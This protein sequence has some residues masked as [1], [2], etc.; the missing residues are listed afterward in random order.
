[1]TLPAP[2]LDDRRFQDLVDE[3]KRHVQQRCPEW[4]D[5]N[6]SDPGVTLIEAF[7]SM[8]DQI[9]YRL[10]RV[11][12]RHYVK[13]LDLLGVQ[14]F[15]PS[16]AG[17]DVTLRL[18]APQPH[19]VAVPAG[20]VVA[21]PRTETVIAVTF[22]TVEDLA[23]IACELKTVRSRI[24]SAE[25]Q[26]DADTTR[27]HDLELEQG[28]GFTC[29]SDEP[30]PDDELLIGLDQ[31]VPSCVVAVRL[32]CDVE[33]LGVDPRDPPLAWEAWTGSDWEAC[34]L[35]LD[36]T[37]GLNKSGY[38][39]LHVPRGHSA[40]ISDGEEIAWLRA[41]ATEPEEGQEPYY[42]S[43]NI[44]SVSVATI[45]GSATAVNASVISDEAIGVSDGLPGQAFGVLHTPM[46]DDPAPIAVDVEIDETW[47]GW[48]EVDGFQSSGE[49]DLHYVVDRVM[50][51]IR[52]GPEVRQ[53]DG[54]VRRFGSPP[55]KD[56]AIR[57]SKYRS[58][59]GVSGNVGPRMISILKSSVP[60]I[61]SV[62][63]LGAAIGGRDGEDIENAKL[64]GPLLVR[65]ANRA[66]TI[67][68]YEQLTIR[69]AREVAR[70]K[71]ITDPE[72]GVRVLVVPYV[73]RTGG[74]ISFEDLIPTD[75]TLERVSVRLEQARVIGA[76]VVVEPPLYRGITVVAEL[77][78]A[79]NA[80]RTEL[81]A[82]AEA[83]LYDYFDPLLGGP[84]GS[85]WPFGR[86]L[87]VG[88]IYSV[89]QPLAGMAL[90]LNAWLFPADPVTGEREEAVERIELSDNAL[91]FSFAHQVSVS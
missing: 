79:V 25:D 41:R 32:G 46:I 89:L 21:T 6:V 9:L 18:S 75:D 54:V 33:G 84:D 72:G 16:A 60:Y 15:P 26:A 82:A 74:R 1:M 86:L 55:Q 51:E 45:G 37:G 56:S 47:E 22:E 57:V 81:Q 73:S 8:T 7:A 29:F 91:A 80:D 31:A 28:D 50:G 38:V 34:G 66:V 23:I 68:D 11:P 53:V 62:Y 49:G 65:A 44:S 13:F 70:V 78:A 52:F 3:A 61:G 69:A 17:V 71:A 14:L 77:K 88:E 4:T 43:P 35:A 36:E 76:R 67:E 64:R 39:H 27:A 10:N 42:Q 2:E 20:T 24:A 30:R 40:I 87:H 63:N 5:H 59:G 19:P 48:T 90:V 58:G 83:A 85:G 12:E